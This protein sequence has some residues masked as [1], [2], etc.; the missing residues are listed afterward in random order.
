M[1]FLPQKISGLV[2]SATIASGGNSELTITDAEHAKN[3]TWRL[4]VRGDTAHIVPTEAGSVVVADAEQTPLFDG[5]EL[6][7]L[8]FRENERRLSIFNGGS[9]SLTVYLIPMGA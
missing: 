7:P 3:K 2:K 1:P 6:F 4:V 8:E 9:A 5:Q